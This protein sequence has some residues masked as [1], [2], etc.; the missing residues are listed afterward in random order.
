LRQ[1]IGDEAFFTALQRY[2]QEHKYG[3]A[4]P[5]DLLNAFEEAAGKSLEAFYNQW[6]YTP[7]R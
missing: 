5:T 2:Y 6:L 1:E 4:T 7:E 3:V